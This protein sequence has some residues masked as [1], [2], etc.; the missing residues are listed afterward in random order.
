[1]ASAISQS[2]ATSFI[3]APAQPE[4]SRVAS[5]ELAD[6]VSML[7]RGTSLVIDS[8]VA[9]EDHPLPLHAQKAIQAA[10]TESL[11]NQG[12]QQWMLAHSN[13]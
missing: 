1:M 9:P 8:K 13:T 10:V 7:Q 11:I 2:A 4:S 5:S 12:S 3:N 6:E